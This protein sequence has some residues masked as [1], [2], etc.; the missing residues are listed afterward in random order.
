MLLGSGHNH[1]SDWWALGVLI[2]EMLTG[3]PP[4]YDKNRNQMFYKIEQAELR[5]PDKKKHGVE[6]SEVAKDLIEKLLDRDPDKRLG[7]KGKGQVL[8]HPFFKN[9]DMDRI[10]R[11]KIKAPF[12][13]K[14]ENPKLMME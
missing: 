13:P 5:W 14:C 10:A 12:V 7:V 11:R 2:Y 6:V 1:T 8:K 9:I 4:F 3:V